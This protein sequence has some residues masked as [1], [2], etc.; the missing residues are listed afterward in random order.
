MPSRRTFLIGIASGM[1]GIA[2]C[3]GSEEEIARCASQGAGSGSTQLRKIVPI[4]GDEQVALG[5]AV[6][7]E[8]VGED[9]DN[10]IEVRNS[11]GT[12]ITS[13]PLADNRDMNQ[14]SADEY[15]VFS[16]T[17]GELYAVPLGPP[18]VHGVLTA[19]LVTSDGE[20]LATETIRFNCYAADGS[21]P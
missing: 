8:A 3:L 12:L 2:G 15:P 20:Q 18:P 13:I 6:A 1:G 14:L 5:I 7:S 10:V 11:D 21:L 16:S 17:D 9:Q 19:S 4:T